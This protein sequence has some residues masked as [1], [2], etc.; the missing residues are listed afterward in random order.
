MPDSNLAASRK[1]RVGTDFQDVG[2]EDTYFQETDITFPVTKAAADSM[3]SDATANTRFWTNPFDF[4]VEVVS[5]KISPGNT[6]TAHDSNYAQVQ[7]K[8]DD[9]AAGTPA[10]ALQWAT[11]T[12]G[13]GNWATSVAENQTTRTAAS[14]IL[15]PGANLWLAIAKQGSGVV[16]PAFLMTVRLR[17]KG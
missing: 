15:V 12:T 10:V 5:A 2:G 7:V 14:C 17:K 1:R 6:L 8:T 11:T 9:A 13:T 4:N 3:A 16:V